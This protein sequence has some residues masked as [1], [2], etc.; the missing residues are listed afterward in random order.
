MLNVSVLQFPH[1]RGIK[2][3]PTLYEVCELLFVRMKW[4]DV[5]KA[6]QTIST[7]LLLASFTS[8]PLR[9]NP[10]T[11]YIPLNSVSLVCLYPP[12]VLSPSLTNG[13]ELC[14]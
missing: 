9:E 6:W 5:C 12:V 13:F 2:I 11:S 7:Q 1:K 4:T 8:L 14:S 3:A 10:L